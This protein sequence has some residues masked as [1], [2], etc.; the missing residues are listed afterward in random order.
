M[1]WS[2]VAFVWCGL[3]WGHF[4]MAP[5]PGRVVRHTE[6]P[7]II[8]CHIWDP[9]IIQ[10]H[11]WDP[12]IIQGRKRSVWFTGY[13]TRMDHTIL[14][15]W[16]DDCKRNNVTYYGLVVNQ[17]WKFNQNIIFRL[18]NPGSHTS[19]SMNSWWPW[20][21]HKPKTKPSKT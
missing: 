7:V 19:E 8:Q 12:V 6:I 2:E 21:D 14:E 1:V 18:R 4:Q 11:I 5:Q 17:M 3:M 16:P 9:V 20:E 10:C 15:R 13:Y